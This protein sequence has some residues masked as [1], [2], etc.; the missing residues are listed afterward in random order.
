MHLRNNYN[1]GI[2]LRHD[3]HNGTESQNDPVYQAW[4]TIFVF[5]SNDLFSYIHSHYGLGLK[6]T[7]SS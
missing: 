5:G 4:Y 7:L 1:K 3:D 2:G 6:E